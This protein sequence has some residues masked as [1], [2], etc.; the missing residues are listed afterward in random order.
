[1][2]LG[3]AVDGKVDVSTGDGPMATGAP[4]DGTNGDSGVRPVPP[5]PAP[6]GPRRSQVDRSYGRVR[7]GAGFGVLGAFDDG[8]A[9]VL[10]AIEG[11]LGAQ[12]TN[13]FGLY[14]QLQL[15]GGDMDQPNG[16]DGRTGLATFAVIAELNIVDELAIGLGPVVMAGARDVDQT[17]GRYVN[18]GYDYDYDR[19]DRYYGSRWRDR[20]DELVS[21][22]GLML[23]ISP[24]VVSERPSGR[25][26]AFRPSFEVAVMGTP[27]DV[28]SPEQPIMV[29]A[30]VSLNWDTW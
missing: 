6:M 22:Y 27:R 5:A 17:G 21:R 13:Y 29:L 1:M 7:G 26:H 14:A 11:R 4:D 10:G 30:G 16:S 25:I 9:G 8:G 24:A 18:G 20:E 3:A 15:A 23:R 2:K 28:V 12:L 19:D